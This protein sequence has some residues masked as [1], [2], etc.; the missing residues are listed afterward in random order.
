MIANKRVLLFILTSFFCF[1]TSL[2][3]VKAMLPTED[4]P[5][6]HPQTA[7]KRQ[8]E[9]IENIDQRHQERKFVKILGG[10]I[11]GLV[12]AY[13]L[14]RLGHS[15][16]IIEASRRIGGRI[17]THTFESTGQYGELGAMRIPDSH[18]YT[19]HYID[20]VGLTGNLRPFVSVHQNPNCLYHLRGKVI[21]MGDATGFLETQYH[22]SPLEAEMLA[23]NSPPAI[24]GKHLEN[25]LRLAHTK[26]I[27]PNDEDSWGGLLGENFLTDHALEYE[28]LTLGEFLERKVESKE[29]KE[30]IG[31]TT[32]LELWWDKALS[33]FLREG[34]TET[35]EGLKEIAGG[36]SQ[37]PH[38]LEKILRNKG[39]RFRLNT[40]V[41]SI[42]VPDNSEEKISLKTRSTDSSKWDSPPTKEEPKIETADFVICTIP[43]GVLRTM[44]LRGLS[45]VKMEAIRSLSYASSTKVLL[46][47]SD[48]F[49]ERGDPNKRIL[50]GASMSDQVTRCTYYPSDHAKIINPIS[51]HERKPFN[52]SFTVSDPLIIEPNEEFFPHEKPMPGV[53]LGSYNWGQDAL[54]LGLLSREE[55]AEVVITEVEKMHPELRQ[56]LL[57]T[58]S[59]MSIS[60]DSYRWSRGAFCGMRPNDMR[61]YHHASKKREG[62]LY[63]AGEH[64]SLDPG[65][66]QGA[67]KSGLDAVEDLLK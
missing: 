16:E 12:A 42:D 21:R 19:H 60:W 36:S 7:V 31:V 45:P 52:G 58:E 26:K 56:H 14:M 62:R 6:R 65:W 38:A 9:R 66:I 35:G 49:W 27:K 51:T 55:R 29:T 18:D 1:L 50:G 46:H 39:V 54:R 23:K 13:E 5:E 8:L 30:L 2:L 61:K 4:K 33:M 28:G 57:P 37:L 22:P 43:F 15:V 20:L 24:L 34:I 47:V 59:E 44:E 48:R 25:A 11:T 17:W 32:G 64:C 41:T 40:E 67:I 10:G 53:L 3:D 63:F